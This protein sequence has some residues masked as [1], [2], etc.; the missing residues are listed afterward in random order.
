VL[1]YGCIQEEIRFL[2]NTELIASLLFTARLQD[3]ECLLSTSPT[4]TNRRSS[5]VDCGSG[6]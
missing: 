5:E 2:I 6:K 3:N 4:F 1:G